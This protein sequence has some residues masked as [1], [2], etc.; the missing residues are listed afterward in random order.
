MQV[1]L[2][3]A[4][5]VQSASDYVFF[6]II[7]RYLTD[8]IHDFGLDVMGRTMAFA[9]GV[10]LVLMTIWLLLQGYRIATGQMRGSMTEFVFNATRAVVIVSTATSMALFGTSLHTFLTIDLNELVTYWLTG[11]SS[12]AAQLIDQNLAY[13]QLAATSIDALQVVDNPAL[14]SAKAR[15]MLLSGAGIA[16]PSAAAAAM[17]LLFHIGMAMFIGFGPLFI[18]ALLFESTRSLFQRWLMYGIGTLFSMAALSFV[19]ALALKV[20]G[21]VAISFWATKITGGLTGTAMSEGLSNQAVQ[22]G[23]VGLLMTALIISTPPMAAMFFQGTLGGFMN[24]SGF[25]DMARIGPNGQ[26]PGSFRGAGPLPP[27]PGAPPA[28]VGR[29]DDG[30]AMSSVANERS[31]QLERAMASHATGGQASGHQPGMQWQQDPPPAYN[32]AMLPKY[33]PAPTTR[34]A[35]PPSYAQAMAA[36][37]GP[38]REDGSAPPSH[39]QATGVQ[40]SAPPGVAP[41]P[42]SYVEVT[43]RQGGHSQGA[44]GQTVAPA[45]P[46]PPPPSASVAAST[47]PRSSPGPGMAAPPN[48]PQQ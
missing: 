32:E 19:T 7:Y 16:G 3:L 24:Y 14:D 42:P 44:A 10:A 25:S 31:G 20:V 29:G 13:M 37:A 38:A 6:Q 17:L 8:R 45:T 40:T 47:R 23:G 11:H 27:M 9:G 18:L 46:V 5:G 28:G 36:E 41:L 15:A 1:V 22:Q 26:P 33:D 2:Y 21:A 34:D 12:G 30:A 4:S 39:A 35:P 48:E 43:S